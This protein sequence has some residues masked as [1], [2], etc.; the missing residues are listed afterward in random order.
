L[1]A[2]DAAHDFAGAELKADEGFD[3]QILGEGGETDEAVVIDAGC[4]KS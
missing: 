1:L 2:K 3:A 4:S